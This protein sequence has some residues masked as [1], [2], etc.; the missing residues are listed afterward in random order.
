MTRLPPLAVLLTGCTA[1]DPFL[2]EVSFERLDVRDLSFEEIGANFV[3]A[4]ENPNPVQIDL[5]SF[6]YALSLEGIELLSGNNDDGVTLERAGRSELVLPL[7]LVFAE[8]LDTIDATRGEDLVDFRLSGSFGFDTPVGR[9]TLPYDALGDFPALR[10]P[11]FSFRALRLERLDLTRAEL[12]LDLGVDNAHGSTLVFDRFQFELDLDG[13]DLVTGL[14]PTFDV[15]GD[16]T[17]AI[18]VPIDIDLLTAGAT[19]VNAILE[20]GKVDLGLF[21]TMD[22]ITPF[23]LL[24]LTVDETG[25]LTI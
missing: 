10:T 9:V 24:P 12:A 4:L 7:D 6:R 5:A 8:L 17:G 20:G 19:L 21:A 22:V 13:R 15:A 11:K 25:R 3:F 14:V 2:P 1:I 23:G 18:T 16:T